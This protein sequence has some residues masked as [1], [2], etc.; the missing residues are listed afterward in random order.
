MPQR[1]Q[2]SIAASQCPNCSYDLKG[3]GN[4]A[5]CPE[6]GWGATAGLPR[7]QNCFYVLSGLKDRRGSCPECGW[8]Y[9]LDNEKSFTRKPPFV[10]WSYWWPVLTV[11]L[12]S[13]LV[14]FL[15]SVFVLGS[16]GW[17]I[18][19]APTLACG[20]I[21]G[22]RLRVGRVPLVL[23]LVTSALSALGMTV[24]GLGGVFCC[25]ALFGI[26]LGPIV[27]GI[28]LGSALRLV[29]K[30]I[31]YAQASWLPVLAMLGAAQAVIIAE[32]PPAPMPVESVGTSRVIATD[33]ETAWDSMMYYE[34]VTHDPP[35][36]LRV[37]LARPLAT[38][39]A[40]DR[41]GA[42]KTCLYNKGYLTKRVTSSRPGE[43]L[44]FEVT[45]QRIG[46]ERD[47]RLRSGAFEFEAIGDERTRVT[48][49]TEYEP[50]LSPRWVWRPF[51]RYAVHTLHGHVLEGMRR[52]AEAPPMTAAV[53]GVSP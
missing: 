33:P 52:E 41:I 24:W 53:E 43:R 32:G 42:T 44:A 3:L 47:V 15:F 16:W 4:P 38:R 19:F 25:L 36:I 35:L 34:Q 49:V 48:L 12:G 21:L 17:S 10:P 2:P 11:A 45:E 14:V 7:C 39:G 26:L 30:R 22:Y 51:E 27:L 8:T 6:C 46:Y 5:V 50:L 31:G 23:V 9:N 37:G 1:N 29:L 18:W 40:M 20:A 28:L 13:S